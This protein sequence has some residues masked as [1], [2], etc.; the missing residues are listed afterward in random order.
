MPI[1]RFLNMGKDGIISDNDPFE[2]PLSAWSDGDNVRFYDGKVHKFLG[3]QQVFGTPTVAP[4]AAFPAPTT[5]TYYWLYPGLQHVY[6]TDGTTHTK[7]SLQEVAP[8]ACT[9]ALAGAGAGNLDN[10]AYSYK[11]TFVNAQGE[12]EAGT[13]SNTITVVDNATNGQIALTAIPTGPATVTARKVYRTEGGGSSYLLLT[14]INDNTTTTYTDNIADGSLG[15]AAPSTNSA[16]VLMTGTALNLWA[17]DS[18]SGIPVITNGKDTPIMWDSLSTSDPMN[19]LTWDASNTWRDKGYTAKVIKAYREYLIALATTESATY[20]PRRLRWST[21]AT[22]GA[23]PTTWDS[24]DA[25]EDA[26]LTDFSEF[27]G[28]LVDALSIRGSMAIYSEDQTWLMTYI[29]G[30]DVMNFQNLFKTSGALATGCVAEFFGQH[31]V[32]TT[33]DVIVHDGSAIQ[34][35]IS[36]RM[37]KWLFSQIDSTNYSLTHVVPNYPKNEL[38]ICFPSAGSSWCDKALIWNYQDN[39]YGVRDLPNTIGSNYGIVDP[40]E[41][42]T[43]ATDTETWDQDTT[44]WD[45]RGYNPTELVPLLVSASNTKFYEPDATNQFDGSSFVSYVEKVAMD[46]GDPS[47]M[48]RLKWLYPRVNG[49]ASMTIKIGWAQ[50]V[51]DSVQWTSYSFDPSTDA[52]RLPLRQVGRYFAIRFESSSNQSWTLNSFDIEYE[53]VGRR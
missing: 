14:T 15:A 40:A 22:S 9:A 19:S 48:K 42:L 37:Q 43:W 27:N 2:L 41:N 36:K 44:Y 4:Y 1:V 16:D 20:Y 24:T 29:G 52:E 32:V 23:V 38:W 13:V 47:T 21:S 50:G 31:L 3:E 11:V 35:V 12:T 17:G 30:D 34:S 39:T 5:S 49:S 25:S 18:I 45:E 33:G 8:G 7:V 53:V 26:G 28:D 51:D 6:V 10:A 46:F